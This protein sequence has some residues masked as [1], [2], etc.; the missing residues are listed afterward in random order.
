M[1]GSAFSL[2]DFSGGLNLR[3]DVSMLAPNE[4]SD[5]SDFVPAGRS[6]RSRDG[7]QA[8]VT[9][10][11]ADANQQPFM[12]PSFMYVPLTNGNIVK[13]DLSSGAVTTIRSGITGTPLIH[14]FINAPAN[15]GQ[16]PLYFTAGDATNANRI[17][18]QYNGAAVAAWT[19]SAGTLPAK[20]RFLRYAGNRAWAANIPGAGTLDDKSAVQWSDIGNPRSWPAENINVFGPN[21]GEEISGIATFQDYVVVFKPSRAWIIYDLDLGANRPLTSGVGHVGTTSQTVA[22]PTPLETPH[23]LVFLDPDQGPMV[24]DGSKLVPLGYKLGDNYFETGSDVSI[25][26]F[27]NRLQFARRSTFRLAEYDVATKTWWSQS[28]STAGGL[29]SGY[30]VSGIVSGVQALYGTGWSG[31]KTI[32]QLMVPAVLTYAD[33]LTPMTPIWTTAFQ[34]FG[35]EGTRKRYGRVRIQ[36]RGLLVEPDVAFDYNS[37]GFAGDVI[38]V[39]LTTGPFERQGYYDLLNLGV[40]R[41]LGVRV[42]LRTNGTPAQLDEIIVYAQERTK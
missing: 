35:A 29:P 41:S 40:G 39:P 28:F 38:N 4:S 12:D 7:D 25:A 37:N 19:A 10:L 15:G 42:E 13:V 32:D 30:V 3:A 18:L 9:G 20:A 11:A 1:R 5:V 2:K 33:G 34:P 8:W 36:G 22:M 6:A 24:Y 31:A 17:A 16:G 26:Y 27:N 14:S 23:G 21:D